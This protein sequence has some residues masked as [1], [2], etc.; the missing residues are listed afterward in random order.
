MF[1][2]EAWISKCM[3]ANGVPTATFDIRLGH[4]LPQIEGK[5]DAMDLLTDAGFS[6]FSCMILEGVLF[7]VLEWPT[8][9]FAIGNP[10]IL[11]M[12]VKY[13]HSNF[14]LRLVLLSIL[15]GRL[16]NFMVQIGLVC[17]SYVTISKGTHWR[18]PTNPLGLP[19]LRFVEDGNE[20]TSKSFGWT[21]LV[22]P[23]GEAKVWKTVRGKLFKTHSRF[24]LRSIQKPC[25]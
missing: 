9:S 7:W 5:Q 23:L 10:N 8:M 19:G 20:F 6:F 14:L 11:Y 4:T 22:F 13:F 2:G 3:R 18:S 12:H 24:F 16:D 17:S 15:N 21:V 25:K 1:G